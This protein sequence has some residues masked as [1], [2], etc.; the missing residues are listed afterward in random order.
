[1]GRLTL[2]D[3]DYV[4]DKQYVRD[5][6]DKYLTPSRRGEMSKNKL[7]PPPRLEEKGGFAGVS[8]D[9]AVLR[10]LREKREKESE[11]EEL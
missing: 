2:H 7:T 11:R 10:M 8:M 1:M 6:I 4:E 5:Y 3:V 9:H